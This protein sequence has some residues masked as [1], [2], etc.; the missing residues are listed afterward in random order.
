LESG[1]LPGPIHETIVGK[2]PTAD[3]KGDS[4]W[5]FTASSQGSFI[6]EFRENA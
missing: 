1:T 4:E 2:Q 5:I 6:I 3:P